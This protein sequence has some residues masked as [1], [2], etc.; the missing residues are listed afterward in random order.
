[1]GQVV[2]TLLQ[3]RLRPDRSETAG[4]LFLVEVA[5]R[6]RAENPGGGRP[7]WVAEK[8]Q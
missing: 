1:M 3:A 2:F 5:A 7:H 8:V 4:V 6:L